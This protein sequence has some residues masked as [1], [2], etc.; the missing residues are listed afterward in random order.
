[1]KTNPSS[2]DTLFAAARNELDAAPDTAPTQDELEYL[3]VRGRELQRLDTPHTRSHSHALEAFWSKFAEDLGQQL[4]QVWHISTVRYAVGI[5][6]CAACGALAVWNTVPPQQSSQ[7]SP[8]QALLPSS[9]SIPPKT[10]IDAPS[11]AMYANMLPY[12]NLAPAH[13][14]PN[15]SVVAQEKSIFSTIKEESH[16]PKNRMNEGLQDI[17]PSADL[18]ESTE[19]KCG[20]ESFEQVFHVQMITEP[21]APT[22][23]TRT[24]NAQSPNAQAASRA[25]LSTQMCAYCPPRKQ[26]LTSLGLP[27]TF[28]NEEGNFP[29]DMMPALLFRY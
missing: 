20:R 26:D 10:S 2:L 19:F 13:Q 1:M 21:N 28:L 12:H 3:L 6:I 17:P 7:F 4:N 8:E 22:A 18:A 24:A 23:N 16:Q 25:K 29:A 14:K 15:N 11:G 9:K 27:E 5:S